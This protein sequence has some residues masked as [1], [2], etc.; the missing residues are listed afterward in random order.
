[1]YVFAVI[2]PVLVTVNELEL[3]TD[4]VHGVGSGM[5]RQSSLSMDGMPFRTAWVGL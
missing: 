1:M 5:T 3:T 2:T 4:I